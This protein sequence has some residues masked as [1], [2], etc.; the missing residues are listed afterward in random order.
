MNRKTLTIMTPKPQH[1]SFDDVV[2]RICENCRFFDDTTSVIVCRK[3]PPYRDANSGVGLW[4]S[5]VAS[6]WC[7]DFK[8]LPSE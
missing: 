2:A 3:R 8:R 6:D 4:P 7:G 1:I 5:V